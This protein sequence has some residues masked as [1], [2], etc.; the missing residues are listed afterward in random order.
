MGP[1]EEEEEDYAGRLHFQFNC[2]DQKSRVQS[3]VLCSCLLLAFPPRRRSPLSTLLSL[4]FSTVITPWRK[5][6][7]QL[8]Q[9]SALQ[10]ESAKQHVRSLKC[11]MV[12]QHWA[13]S[14]VAILVITQR[15][16]TWSTCNNPLKQ[17]K[18]K[19][20]EKKKDFHCHWHHCAFIS[21]LD[22]ECK[23]DESH[24]ETVVAVKVKKMQRCWFVEF[25][26]KPTQ[27]LS[28][29]VRPFADDGPNEPLCMQLLIE[30]L[31][32]FYLRAVKDETM[33]RV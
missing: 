14:T 31:A 24:V 2:I 9:N 8:E 11:L 19:E 21:S 3:T 5:S 29:S 33:K 6:K 26:F 13:L 12:V 15:S 10:S 20:K 27:A 7:Q 17:R 32:Q 25:N 18:I 4:S 30:R 28:P 1:E 16:A 23:E 22:R